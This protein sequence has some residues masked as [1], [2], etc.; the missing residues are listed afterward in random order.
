MLRLILTL[1]LLA[2]ASECAHPV[3]QE[4]R[5]SDERGDKPGIGYVLRKG[6]GQI[7]GEAAIIEAAHPHDFSHGRSAAMTI[8]KQSPAEMTVHVRWNKD[9]EATFRIQFKQPDWPDSFDAVVSELIGAEAY[10]TQ[11][12]HFVR[13]QRPAP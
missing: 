13:V 5:A 7:T 9:L 6:D 4:W 2:T 1:S 12:Y 3:G 8:L 10:D 11:T